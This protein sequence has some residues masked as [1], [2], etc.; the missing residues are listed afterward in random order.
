MFRKAALLSLVLI[1]AL[2]GAGCP[3]VRYGRVPPTARLEADLTPR[4]STKADVLRVLGPPRGYGRAQLRAA[5]TP[6]DTWFYEAIVAPPS[7]DV[8]I[9]FLLVYFDGEVF[10]GYFWFSS[11]KDAPP[12]LQR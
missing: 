2:A 10:D 1:F 9:K 3:T 7:G 6:R 8:R 4:V 11:L 12:I 5:G